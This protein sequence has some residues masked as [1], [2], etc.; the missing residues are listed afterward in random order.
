LTAAAVHAVGVLLRN[1]HADLAGRPL[2]PLCERQPFAEKVVAVQ[3]PLIRRVQGDRARHRGEYG[4]PQQLGP[5][6]EVAFE[7]QT[8]VER[9]RAA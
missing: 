6:F 8:L 9:G 5:T 4:T 3:P 2:A 1:A 7:A